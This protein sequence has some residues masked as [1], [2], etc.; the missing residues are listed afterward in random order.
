VTHCFH[1]VHSVKRTHC[2]YDK[3]YGGVAKAKISVLKSRQHFLGAMSVAVDGCG[4]AQFPSR[5][6]L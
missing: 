6:Y 5:K 2:K 3:L 1:F 4:V